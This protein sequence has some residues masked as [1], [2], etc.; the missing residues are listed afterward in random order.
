MVIIDTLD[1]LSKQKSE[2]AN[3]DEVIKRLCH[4]F[5]IPHPRKHKAQ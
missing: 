3:K 1:F 4:D 2:E 5:R